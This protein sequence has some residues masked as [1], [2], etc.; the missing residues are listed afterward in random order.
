MPRSI[1]ME[2]LSAI[3]EVSRAANQNRHHDHHHRHREDDDEREHEDGPIEHRDFEVEQFDRLEVSGPFDVEVET[4]AE[5]GVRASGPEWALDN[6]SVEHDGDRLFIG[7]DG[8]VDEVSVFVTVREL[9]SVR[10]SER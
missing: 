7:C 4:G 8:E 10:S 3:V 6:L 2:I 1:A 5:P 9:R